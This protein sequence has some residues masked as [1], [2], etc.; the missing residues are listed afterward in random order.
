M[1][2]IV[3]GV[4]AAAVGK[5]LSA[6]GAAFVTGVATAV[7][8][9]IDT[10]Y[11]YPA[12]FGDEGSRE[13]RYGSVSVQT[14]DEGS[15]I[16][17][18]FGKTIRVPALLLYASEFREV[19]R[20]QR[21][22]KRRQ[23]APSSF[24][25]DVSLGFG[26][27]Y[28]ATEG[29]LSAIK[30]I[31]A[32]SRPILDKRDPITADTVFETQGT[33]SSKDAGVILDFHSGGSW[34]VSNVGI[35]REFFSNSFLLRTT[36]ELGDIVQVTRTRVFTES[37]GIQSYD[38]AYEMTFSAP[39]GKRPGS[40]FMVRFESYAAPYKW[41]YMTADVSRPNVAIM[42][43]T[44]LPGYGLRL[45]TPPPNRNFRPGGI[46]SEDQAPI[47]TNEP[48]RVA[49]SNPDGDPLQNLLS[50]DVGERVTFKRGG[51]T[52]PMFDNRVQAIRGGFDGIQSLQYKDTF[53]GLWFDAS[54]GDSIQLTQNRIPYD[55]N[56]IEGGA[57]DVELPYE[58]DGVAFQEASPLLSDWIIGNPVPGFRDMATAQISNCNVSSYGS[59]LPNFE[60]IIESSRDTVAEV[61]RDICVDCGLTDAQ[62]DTSD[63][64]SETV[65]GY[66][67][68][69][70]V[71][72][73]QK[74]Q[75]LLLVHDVVVQH[76]QGALRFLKRSDSTVITV[77]GDDLIP[78][79]SGDRIVLK[80]REGQRPARSVSINFL[81]A[82]NNLEPGSWS[83]SSSG[84]L[85]ESGEDIVMNLNCVMS[86]D[87]AK[88][89]AKRVIRDASYAGWEASLS[90]PWAFSEIQENDIISVMVDSIQYR[91]RV[92]RIDYGEQLE[93]IISGFTEPELPDSPVIAPASLGASTEGQRVPARQWIDAVVWRGV[94]WQTGKFR[95][96]RLFCAAGSRSSEGSFNGASVFISSDAGSTWRLA[97]FI[98][99]KTAI[100]RVDAPVLPLR[101]ASS[102]DW[103]P[104]SSVAVNLVDGE[105]E[106]ITEKEA[107]GGGSNL[108]LLG[109]EVVSFRDAERLIGGDYLLSG[110]VR[111]I[112]GSG[113]GNHTTRERFVLLGDSVRRVDLK[114]SEV[115]HPIRVRVVAA[116]ASIDDGIEFTFDGLTG[117]SEPPI[118]TGTAPPLGAR[119]VL[120][121][122]AT[123]AGD[124]VLLSWLPTDGAELY[125]I[126]TG[127]AWLGA[128]VIGR[129]NSTNYSWM[130]PRTGTINFQIR[131]RF[132]GGLW[133]PSVATASI[134]FAGA[135]A[136][137]VD[138]ETAPL[139]GTVGGSGVDAAESSG[140]VTINSDAY[141]GT[142]TQS[143]IDAGSVALRYWTID[144]EGYATDSRTVG[145]L[146]DIIPATYEGQKWTG[147][148]RF[149]DEDAPGV[150]DWTTPAD[151]PLAVENYPNL[152]G[153]G[154][155]GTPGDPT[156]VVI[157]ARFDDTGAGSWTSWLPFEPQWRTSQK[158]Q[159]R[160]KLRR[161]GDHMQQTISRFRI[162]ARS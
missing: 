12:L 134:S 113:A 120:G 83:D 25:V 65:S 7:G 162:Q 17:A 95:S 42:P 87:Q 98:N 24:Y 32:D 67:Y 150:G 137:A 4:G 158:M 53:T 108:A 45:V 62:I 92:Q 26:K 94:D 132:P 126:R 96:D 66:R 125:E 141:E 60:A 159:A 136:T 118:P 56:V 110:F 103:E 23:P 80:R 41:A 5:G 3:L 52:L 59:R 84:S 105:M 11:I 14:A 149:G 21:V 153:Y 18:T 78:T 33:G 73:R 144:W 51:S 15:P 49:E 86:A 61:L 20:T 9:Y 124:S 43:W 54:A 107:R 91:I 47:I 6:A 31:L 121:F 130:A 119:N 22:G 44:E 152:R 106:S 81:D 133:S 82:N 10:A 27:S 71:D 68:S 19:P 148:G 36:P 30:A 75:P 104:D 77:D 38:V 154:V 16:Y 35:G 129:T 72:A 116:G 115:D 58:A 70:V 89:I 76:N 34:R 145:E 13:P 97:D 156:Q 69:G 93:L 155:A 143:Q 101:S 138:T 128:R 109:D 151:Y 122:Q 160:M 50:F 88:A 1:A 37:D 100:G 40:G 161:V 111:G 117:G 2:S 114:P 64:P 135:D 99:A 48:V 79:Q 74:L 39:H 127:T 57:S 140:L 46:G 85:A 139:P 8:G 29:G 63:L 157:E 131:A 123:D 112:G 146:P 28:P 102:G 55:L 142:W 147:E 90:L